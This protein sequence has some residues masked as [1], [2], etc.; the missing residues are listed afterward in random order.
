MSSKEYSQ[1]FIRRVEISAHTVICPDLR[2]VCS[3]T[4]S[5]CL[6]PLI[7]EC[8][9][10]TMFFLYAHI[11]NDVQSILGTVRDQQ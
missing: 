5:G 4:P 7:I 9:I 3:K 6:K 1:P 8:P 11:Y 10:Y 2:G